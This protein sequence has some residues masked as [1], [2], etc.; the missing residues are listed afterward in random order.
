MGQSWLTLVVDSLA[1]PAANQQV[2]IDQGGEFPLQARWRD[3]KVIG[4][5]GQVP[6]FVWAE[7]DSR[8]D[9]LSCSREEGI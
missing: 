6:P 3:S 7:Q 1:V 2:P 5:V 8:Q 9:S 4:K